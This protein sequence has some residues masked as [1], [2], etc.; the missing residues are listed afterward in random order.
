MIRISDRPLAPRCRLTCH[1]SVRPGACFFVTKRSSRDGHDGGVVTR[2][3]PR[4]AS[5]RRSTSPACQARRGAEMRPGC[6]SP[7]PARHLT[8][9]V[10]P[11]AGPRAVSL[12][13]GAPRV[14]RA[15]TLA[16]RPRIEC[17]LVEMGLSSSAWPART[18]S[19]AEERLADEARSV[20]APEAPGRG[21]THAT[22]PGRYA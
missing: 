18:S 22:R 4:A 20:S 11:N 15:S 21:T 8:R 9:P 19:A 3:H 13:K 10:C 7:R 14:T 12:R 17:D 16:A 1:S 5:N 2:L 6:P